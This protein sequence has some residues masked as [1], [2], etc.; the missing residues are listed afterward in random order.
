ML[1]ITDVRIRKLFPAGEGKLRAIASITLDAAFAVHGVRVVDGREKPFIAM[2]DHK[3]KN[4]T[5]ANIAH[6]IN[7]EARA[8][9]EKAVISK[10]DEALKANEA[11]EE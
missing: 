11:Q 7:A 2:P 4:G 1:N 5:Y 6:P 3:F 10:Y 9:I 8:D